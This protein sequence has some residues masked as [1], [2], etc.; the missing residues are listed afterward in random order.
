MSRRCEFTGVGVMSGNNVSHSKRRT[1]RKFRP[2]LCNV[3]LAS[4]TLEQSFKFRITAAALRSVDH[5]G[6]LDGFLAKCK[7]EDM[8]DAALKVKKSIRKKQKEMAAA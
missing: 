1:R 2:N 7:D 5:N 3:T 6:G 8:S 4:D